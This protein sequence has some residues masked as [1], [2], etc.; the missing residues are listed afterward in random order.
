MYYYY[1]KFFRTNFHLSANKLKHHF[2][3]DKV[4]SGTMKIYE[5]LF[6]LKIVKSNIPV[7]HEDVFAYKVHDNQ[8]DEFLGNF[9]LDL[10]QR[11]GKFSHKGVTFTLQERVNTTGF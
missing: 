7:W 9:Y 3:V 1:K 6:G 5:K 4:L 2:P 10:F 11:S 8:T